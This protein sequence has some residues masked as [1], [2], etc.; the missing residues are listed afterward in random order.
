MKH[1]SD[2]QHRTISIDDDDDNPPKQI[3][4]QGAPNQ[5]KPEIWNL[6]NGVRGGGF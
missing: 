4:A 3:E 5:P 6:E 2:A 1:A